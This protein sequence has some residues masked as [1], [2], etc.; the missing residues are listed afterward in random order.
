MLLTF[1]IATSVLG[2]EK[3]NGNNTEQKNDC[4]THTVINENT[5]VRNTYT[6]CLGVPK[7]FNAHEK[8]EPKAASQ[9]N[10]QYL[11]QIG[12]PFKSFR[13]LHAQISM[14][15]STEKIKTYTLFG[16][17][18]GALGIYLLGWTLSETRKASVY[19]RQT[20]DVA[21]DEYRCELAL[22]SPDHI[23]GNS[24]KRESPEFKVSFRINIKNSGKTPAYDCCYRWCYAKKPEHY[25]IT[26]FND[27]AGPIG[28]GRIIHGDPQGFNITHT[29]TQINQGTRI[30]LR[31]ECFD[32]YDDGF[33]RDFLLEFSYSGSRDTNNGTLYSWSGRILPTGADINYV[34]VDI[35]FDAARQATKKR[36]RAR[37]EAEISKSKFWIASRWVRELITRK[38]T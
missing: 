17:V 29:F 37:A 24:F 21:R 25:L 33:C 13:D 9:H 8:P 27:G 19:A 32:K 4:E 16:V 11:Q 38:S 3:N 14:A 31:I 23:S 26:D 30:F 6:W 18:I 12:E 7:K 2:A 35:P 28:D 5:G 15:H 10:K 34:G 20:L 22:V 36:K 1:V